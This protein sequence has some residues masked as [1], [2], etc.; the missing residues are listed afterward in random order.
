MV[1]GSIIRLDLSTFYRG[2]ANHVKY[3]LLKEVDELIGMNRDGLIVL[4]L[5]EIAL[6]L[7]YLRPF[8]RR[9]LDDLRRCVSVCPHGLH[10][11]CFATQSLDLQSYGLRLCFVAVVCQNKIGSS[12]C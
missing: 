8:L 4:L 7:L 6:S 1:R 11:D 5:S 2:Q 12:F 9:C 3:A 10:N